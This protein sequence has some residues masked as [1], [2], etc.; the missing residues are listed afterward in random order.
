MKVWENPNKKK[1]GVSVWQNPNKKP[2]LASRLRGEHADYS[3]INP[4][5][6]GLAE[7][8]LNMGADAGNILLQALHQQGAPE[9]FDMGERFRRQGAPETNVPQLPHANFRN[10]NPDIAKSPGAYN[11]GKYAPD[12]KLLGIPAL[13]ALGSLFGKA[14]GL[15]KATALQ[16]DFR[17]LSVGED[18]LGKRISSGKSA[19]EESE[20]ELASKLAN[21]VEHHSGAFE[22]RGKQFKEQFPQTEEANINA[23]AESL[24]EAKDKVIIPGIKKRYQEFGQ[25]PQGGMSKIKD[26]IPVTAL[27]DDLKGIEKIASKDL[28]ETINQAIGHKQKM[29]TSELYLPQK[30]FNVQA[31]PSVND[32]MKLWKTARDEAGSFAYQSKFNTTLSNAQK[33]E[34]GK[35]AAALYKLADKAKL[36]IQK[37]LPSAKRKEYQSIQEAFENLEIPFRESTLLKNATARHP[38]ITTKNF[39]ESLG[40]EN[41]PILKEYLLEKHPGFKETAAK[42][43]LMGLDISNPKAIERA[44]QGDAGKALPKNVRT[45]LQGMLNDV[46]QKKIQQKSYQGMFR[47]KKLA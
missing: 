4:L 40:K 22:S 13:K 15:T 5:S 37:T 3:Q 30:Q 21:E 44:L 42:Y 35:Q 31:K 19:L 18:V 32:Y 17:G 25:D 43:D 27:H 24:T 36:S 41:K 29:G 45:D 1:Q 47:L 9:T 10:L 12:V 28:K 39:M 8:G 16:R 2:T 7:A 11:V 20:R 46:R 38:K 33:A 23:L 34:M 26:P 6:A 14:T